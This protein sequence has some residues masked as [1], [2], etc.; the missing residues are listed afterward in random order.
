MIPTIANRIMNDV[1]ATNTIGVDKVTPK[2][3]NSLVVHS[4]ALSAAIE[5]VRNSDE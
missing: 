2:K 1:A 3:P 5:L 4:V